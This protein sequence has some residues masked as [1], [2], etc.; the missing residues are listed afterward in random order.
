VAHEH[1]LDDLELYL[2][3]VMEERRRGLVPDVLRALATAGSWA[4]D[5]GV[6]L[7]LGLYARGLLRRHRGPLPVISV[8]NLTVGGT[9]KT[10]FVSYLARGLAGQNHKPAILARGYRAK[11]KGG[12]NDELLM[13]SRQCPGLLTAANPNRLAGCMRAREDGA[14]VALLDDGFQHLALQR[15][16]DVLLVDATR[17][18]GNGH[19][20]PRGTLREPAEHA[21]RADIVV[22]TRVD[23]AGLGPV[24]ELRTWLSRLKPG[25]PI[26]E[27]SFQARELRPLGEDQGETLAAEEL[28]GKRVGAFAALAAPRGFGQTL[29]A[30]GA[31][32][33]YS[34]RF[35]DHHLYTARDLA[36]VVAEAGASGA[37]M[38]VTTEK[39]AVKLENLPAP[40]IPIYCLTIEAEVESGEDF[41]WAEVGR[42]ISNF[43]SD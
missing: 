27:C 26:I 31:T 3:G 25:V 5:A 23:L 35:R 10:P 7:R 30:Q 11:S 32:V 21:A 17:P 28:S 34:R 1:T 6:H 22:L 38:L 15:D 14:D 33:V 20:L 24:G 4:F 36:G 41:L 16:L 40:E 2:L 8:G 9:G 42:A 39:D 37:E 13:L 19:L 12:S 29:R 18:F 43:K